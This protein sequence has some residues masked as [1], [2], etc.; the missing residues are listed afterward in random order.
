[1]C[2]PTKHSRRKPATMPADFQPAGQLHLLAYVA[3]PIKQAFRDHFDALAVSH[4]RA[5]GERLSTH[6]PM[7]C[8]DDD[9]YDDLA[10]ATDIHELPDI[11][12]SMGFGDFMTPAFFRRFVAKGCFATAHPGPIHPAFASS[13]LLDPERWYT[14][15][16]VW[17]HVLLVD[18]AKLGSRPVPRRWSDLLDPCYANQIVSDGAHDQR[19]APIPLLH[20]YKEHGE[21]G[22]VQLAQNI[23]DS[24]H[25]A[26]MVKAAGSAEKK[27]AGIYIVPWS[28]ARARQWPRHVRLIWPEEGAIASPLYAW[29]KAGARG[30]AEVVAQALV[31]KKLGNQCAQ[32]GFPVLNPDVN[33]R[34]PTEASFC[35]LGWDYVRRHNVQELVDVTAAIAERAWLAK[36]A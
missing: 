20:F 11:I 6:I 23:R 29:V 22:L 35:W 1:M 12:A 26:E 17:A 31:S 24:W 10:D 13:G 30:A 33:N 3:C 15:Y 25:P 28:F 32:A 27:G 34:L 7:G 18:L 36:A 8:R 14:P 19:F 9:P 16:S 21:A 4:Y 5:T 2:S